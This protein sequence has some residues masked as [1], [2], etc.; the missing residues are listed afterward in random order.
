MEEKK[1]KDFDA[2]EWVRSVRD[3]NY[4]RLGHLPVEEYVRRLDEEGKNSPLAKELD[5]LRRQRKKH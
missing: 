5:E 3:A 1:K 2:V 4:K